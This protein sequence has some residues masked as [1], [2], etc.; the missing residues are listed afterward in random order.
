MA[1]ARRRNHWRLVTA[2]VLL[3]LLLASPCRCTGAAPATTMNATTDDDL[4][5]L[6][7]FKALINGD[8]EG[9]LSSWVNTSDPCGGWR[10]VGCHSLRHPRRV[11]S[12]EL[13]SSGL[14]GT[15]S[16]YLANLTFLR[17]LNL[18]GNLL[19]G[20]IPR[21]L[22]SLRRL[23]ELDLS[24]NNLQGEIPSSLTR[25]SRLRALLLGRNSLVG[26]IPA[27]LSHCRHLEVLDVGVNN[28]TGQAHP[29]L[30]G[31]ASLSN[32]KKLRLYTNNIVGTIPCSLGNLTSLV[33]LSM[34]RNRLVGE[35]PES[36]GQMTKLRYLHLAFN[37]LSGTIPA[38]IFNLSSIRQIQLSHNDLSGVIPNDVGSTLPN[39]EFL[40]LYSCNFHGRIPGSLGNASQ[41][42]MIELANNQ[43]HG[44]VPLN[45]GSLRNLE[46][47]ALEN[48]QLLEASWQKDWDLLASLA[49]CTQLFALALSSKRFRGPF[50]PS[51]ANLSSIEMMYLEGNS[52]YGEISPDITKLE[53]LTNFQ[54]GGNL[55]TGTIP[56]TIGELHD[57]Q[58]LE[59]FGNNIQGLIPS[60][61]GNLTRLFRLVLSHN[62]LMG[63]IPTS[64]GWLDRMASL[65]LS[66][67][68][69]RGTIP[70]QLVSLTSLTKK[71]DLSHNFLHGQIPFEIGSLIN[72]VQLD[73]SNNKLSGEIPSPLGKCTELASLGLQNNIL[74]GRIPLSL[75][76][77]KGIQ[78]V[79]LSGNN[80]TGQIPTFF[81][82]L[83]FL[84]YMNI[85]YNNLDGPIPVSGVFSNASRIFLAGNQV[86]GGIPQLHLPHC[87]PKS[88]DGK[89]HTPR[90]YLLIIICTVFGALSIFVMLFLYGMCRCSKRQQGEG[91][92]PLSED[93]HWQVSF[94]DLQ[95]A[96]NHFSPDSL[97]G[98]GSF[99][100]VYR[101]TLHNREVA[102]KVLN[103]LQQG[104]EGS[105]LRECHA[106][107]SMRHRNL[108]KIITVC[109]SVDHQGNDFKALVYEFM[110]NGDLDSW[111]HTSQVM[112]GEA[113]RM[114]T[115][116]QRV[117]TALDIAQALD[118]LHNR[119]QSPIVHCDMKPSNVLLDNDMVAHV[120]DFGLSR[121][122]DKM[123][124]SGSTE[125]PNAGR[126]SGIRGSIGYIAPEY[127]MGG[128][129][130][131]DGDVYSYG[132][133]L[134][135]MFTG[136]SPTDG[137]FQGDHTLRFYVASNYPD[138]V[139]EIVDPALLQAEQCSGITKRIP[140]D[141]RLQ[142]C[143]VAVFH[144][145][146]QC[147]EE[148]PRTRMSI[149]DAINELVMLREKFIE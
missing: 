13:T 67:N 28:L 17:T 10:G 65:D 115:M 62:N 125:D 91:L 19:A 87:T 110:R 111:L 148:S 35:I 8:P 112:E 64:F 114:L 32:L 81:D 12:V 128:E 55:L 1:A 85:S 60:T 144:V 68:Q 121:F 72:L 34:G 146:L 66:H 80:L 50:P 92:Q 99:G 33:I 79:D 94:L 18:S 84:V 49:N 136:K 103:L 106:L 52:I 14:S 77:L 138:R 23:S 137:M 149:R 39:L 63:S 135:E 145:G 16:P 134:L 117:N 142:G 143:L 3:V 59:L 11:T 108:V 53:K 41:L 70:T 104:A 147:T 27:N 46:V 98:T 40:L 89:K 54:I 122:V 119:G 29:L 42:V 118:Y 30:L 2:P 78:E 57:L 95:R 24:D 38:S 113:P 123:M 109:T 58:V 141:T 90:R 132:V 61:I 4:R 82:S 129:V 88:S 107:R 100:A 31:L 75:G 127:G 71:L 48:N 126:S 105:F 69:L 21:E 5:A 36:F 101:A 22:G 133:I 130:S 25:S 15:V 102:I 73:F 6:L 131:I 86:C 76:S 96:T 26:E 97:V 20:T 9:A 44:S 43:L 139:T 83:P 74:T 140:E 124:N 45:I 51:I 37:E 56:E 93:N 7:S 47:L 120:G 116:V